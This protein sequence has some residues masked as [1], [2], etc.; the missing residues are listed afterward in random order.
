MVCAKGTHKLPVAIVE[1]NINHH[2]ASKERK[3]K[4]AD[5]KA[6]FADK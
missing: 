6:S 2:H 5:E 4:I 3:E 1:K